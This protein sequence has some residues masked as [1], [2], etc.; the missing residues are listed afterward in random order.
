M[1]ELKI[2]IK[3]FHMVFRAIYQDHFLN[4]KILVFLSTLLFIGFETEAI[5]F[6]KPS[7]R[8][9]GS[10]FLAYSPKKLKFDIASI[11][12][13]DDSVGD[14]DYTFHESIDLNASKHEFVFV[15]LRY[16]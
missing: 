16:L 9:A 10:N 11:S 13:Q 5:N 6:E 3:V 8:N 7:K 4:S 1:Q 14:P 2:V 15:W 12:Y